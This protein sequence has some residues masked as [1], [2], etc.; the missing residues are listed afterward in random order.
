[1]PEPAYVLLIAF[2]ALL[3]VVQA[4]VIWLQ[5]RGARQERQMYLTCI[6]HPELVPGDAPRKPVSRTW[7]DA[8]EAQLERE[9]R[10]GELARLNER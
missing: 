6:T 3:N 2:L 8:G 10:A 1:M 7:T 4:V 9:K 5:D